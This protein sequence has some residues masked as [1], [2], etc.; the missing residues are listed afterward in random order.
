MSYIELLCV[1]LKKINMGYYADCYVLTNNRT[2]MFVDRFLNTF[3]PNRK[4]QAE[5]YEVPQY[6]KETIEEF[7]SA[8]RLIDYLELNVN[9]PHTIY[10]ENI[11]NIEPRFANCFFT[12]D[13]N[14][15]VGLGINA[16]EKT[17]D[18]LLLKLMDFC[19]TTEGYITYE[20]PA[21]INSRE[22]VENVRR[23]NAQQKL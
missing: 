6:G 5:I 18:E 16:N 14:L 21:P 10:W 22:F 4:E 15:I 1:M 9:T 19:G 11:D 20:Q 17:E 3:I 23:T 12:D 2:K 7:D 8:D 13:N